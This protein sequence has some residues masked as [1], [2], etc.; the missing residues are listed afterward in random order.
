MNKFWPDFRLGIRTY[1]KSF[2]F[3]V[4]NKMMHFYLYPLLFIILFSVGATAGI[5]Y[6]NDTVNP[7]ILDIIGAEP[8]PGDGW[9]EITL[10][11]LSNISTYVV[12]FLVWLIMIYIFYKISKYVVL[13]VMSPVMALISEK[14]DAVV[15]GQNFPFSW[16]QLMKDVV[17]GIRIALRNFIFEMS[18]TVG[19][20]IVNLFITIFLAPLSVITSPAVLVINFLVS[21]YYF[22]F[23]TMDYTNERYRVSFRDS[24][25]KIRAQR[26]LAVANGGIFALWLMIPILGTFIGTVFAPVT[27]TVGATLALLE[28]REKGEIEG[29]E[30]NI[31]Q[32]S[33]EK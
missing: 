25:K 23:S 6:I 27:C 13:I 33:I 2:G 21:A 8:V 19:L 30:L 9:W 15:T 32:K 26:G 10:N 1:F 22:G 16:K 20:L 5:G 3:I 18:I 12:S 28:K 31:D 11:F 7:W 14:T 29:Y 4:R 24:V 17:R